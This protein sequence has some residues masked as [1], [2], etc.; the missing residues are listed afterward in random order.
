[1]TIKSPKTLFK[2]ISARRIDLRVNA[3]DVDIKQLY[4]EAVQLAK[5][6]GSCNVRL[7]INVSGKAITVI[8]GIFS[9]NTL[10][11]ETLEK[12]QTFAKC[13]Y[14]EVHLSN[15][16][17]PEASHEEPTLSVVSAQSIYLHLEL[18]VARLEDKYREAVLMAKY[19]QC[20]DVRFMLN[21]IT[22][23]VNA[24]SPR[25]LTD[26]LSNMICYYQSQKLA[27]VH[28]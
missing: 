5:F 8:V 27:E 28:C 24:L 14:D 20:Y 10:T 2:T 15:G 9:A 16:G 17:E 26:E 7:P 4:V 19:T 13:G 25:T 12:I 1:M 11:Q 22:I 18:S 3:S 6:T 21:N 23:V